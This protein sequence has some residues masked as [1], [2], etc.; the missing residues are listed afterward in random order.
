MHESNGGARWCAGMEEIF[1]TVTKACASAQMHSVQTFGHRAEI[2][3]APTVVWVG[4]LAMGDFFI[5]GLAQRRSLV[6]A[7]GAGANAD[8]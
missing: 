4:S 8:T 3:T 1:S 2:M 6:R 5:A 7:T